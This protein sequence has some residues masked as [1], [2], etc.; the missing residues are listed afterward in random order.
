MESVSVFR[1]LACPRTRAN[2]S[3]EPFMR[4]PIG[5]ALLVIGIILF[6]IG[7]N[8]S[9]SFASDVSKFFTGS[10]TDKAVWMMIG[11]VVAIIAGAAVAFV[12]GKMLKR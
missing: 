2:L 9:Q 12:P 8:A 6:I 7:V 10:P 11:G 3:T 5:L 1:R 4:L